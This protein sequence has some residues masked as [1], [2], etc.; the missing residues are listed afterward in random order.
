[1]LSIRYN[2]HKFEKRS[3]IVSFKNVLNKVIESVTYDKIVLELRN[4]WERYSLHKG[5]RLR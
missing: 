2:T 4:Y 3:E 1:M 5:S